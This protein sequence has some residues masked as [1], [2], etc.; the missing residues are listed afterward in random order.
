MET[1]YVPGKVVE[2]SI[3][4]LKL[5]KK[6]FRIDFESAGRD[7]GSEEKLF[8]EEDIIGM[9]EDIVTANGLNPQENLLVVVEDGKNI[10]IEGNR[11]LLAINCILNPNLVPEKYRAEFRRVIN[12]PPQDLIAKLKNVNVVFIR[13]RN[14]AKQYIASK[15]SGES[16]L[17]WSL[18][19]QWRHVKY[20]YDTQDKDLNKTIEVLRIGRDKVISSIKWF[21][22]IEYGRK[23]GYWDDEHLREQ[24]SRNR[25]EASRMTRALQFNSVM[26]ALGITFNENYDLT[27]SSE[28]TKEKFDFVLFKFLKSSLL[29]VRQD[30]IDTRT[31]TSDILGLISRWKDEYDAAHPIANTPRGNSQGNDSNTTNT[32]SDDDTRRQK[33]DSSQTG[34]HETRNHTRTTRSGPPE[35]YL[36]SLYKGLTIEDSRIRGVT[37]ELKDINYTKNPIAALMLIRSLLELTLMYQIKSKGKEQELKN[38]VR[39]EPTLDDIVKFTITNKSS[40]FSDPTIADPLQYVQQSGGHRKFLNDV[41][42]DSWVDPQT[43]H[44]EVISGDL[45]NFFKAVLGGLA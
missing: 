43:G 32:H 25:L 40:L 10:V 37:K 9:A 14:E 17:Q 44:V 22:I 15:H 36:K 41:V 26:S 5:D 24:I 31:E 8:D 21:N 27:H 16:T 35:R 6:N 18:I 3:S 45:R 1:D 29:D 11:R 30:R 34:G 2:M 42:H 28:F 33:R 23:L 12:N 7:G 13:S 20:E 19:S 39:R 38:S 4:A